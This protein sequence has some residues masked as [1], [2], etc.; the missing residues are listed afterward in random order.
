ML[1]PCGSAC[2]HLAPGRLHTELQRAR[3]DA[4]RAGALVTTLETRVDELRDKLD[5]A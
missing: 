5:E 3:D 1:V 4:E 2:T